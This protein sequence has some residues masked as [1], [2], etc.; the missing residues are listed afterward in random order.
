MALALS[1]ENG[2]MTVSPAQS[3]VA[4]GTTVA[5]IAAAINKTQGTINLTNGV[6]YNIF[7]I[8]SS[9]TVTNS[10]NAVTGSG[11][12]TQYLFNNSVLNAAVTTN[13]SAGGS[14]VNTYG[15]GFV[16]RIYDA[17][18]KSANNGQGIKI[19]G[20]TVIATNYTNGDQT[21]VPFTGLNM[22][23]IAANGQGSVIPIPFDLTEAVRNT[24]YQVGT[25]TIAKE[26]YLSSLT[27]LSYQLP[28]NT[29]MSWTFFTEASSFKG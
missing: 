26:F 16:G 17:Y 4:N 15:D 14:I 13:G 25:L 7:T 6:V 5:T 18:L 12:V 22:N 10:S 28:A 8:P 21:S 2:T 27:Q 24:Q 3:A 19:T 9:F 20:F 29:I 23:L 11:T 1:S